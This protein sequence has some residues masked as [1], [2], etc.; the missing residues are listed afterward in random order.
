MIE[1]PQ[2]TG[3]TLSSYARPAAWQPMALNFATPSR[4]KP[5][6]NDKFATPSKK[7]ELSLFS[8][9]LLLLNN[10]RSYCCRS[11]QFFQEAATEKAPATPMPSL[12]Q[13]QAVMAPYPTKSPFKEVS[14]ILDLMSLVWP[15]VIYF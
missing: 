4:A 12:S 13:A 1:I 2:T 7:V 5:K 10:F 11:S 3:R 6:L 15:L 14:E 8:K 9:F